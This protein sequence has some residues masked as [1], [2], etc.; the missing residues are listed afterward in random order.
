MIRH[1]RS[2]TGDP[3]NLPRPGIAAV[4]DPGVGVFRMGN[5]CNAG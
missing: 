1:V 4:P 3:G 5:N 2:E